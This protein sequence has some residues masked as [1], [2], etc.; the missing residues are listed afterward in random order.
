MTTLMQASQQWRSR[1]ADER[2][3]SLVE[4]QQVMHARR[5]LSTQDVVTTRKLTLYPAPDDEQDRR[6]RG[7]M[8]GVEGGPLAG[9]TLSPTHMAFGQLCSLAATPS[10]ASYFRESGL[11][12]AYIADCLNFNLRVTRDIGD[13]GVLGHVDQFGELRAATGPNYGRV[14]DADVVDALVDRFGDG[15]TE[16][17]RVPGEFGRRVT[18]T[19]ANTT[20]FASDRDMF[21]FLAD[22]ERRIDVAGRSLARG[23]FVWNSEVGDKTLGLGFFLFD[24]VCC[25]RIVWGADQYTEVRVRHTKGAPDRWLEEVAPVLSEYAEGSG[26][27][28]VE[29]IEAA[30]ERKIA[31]DLDKLLATRF[32]K[33]MVEPIKAIHLAEEGR[34]IETAWDVTVAATA[35]A[36][37]IPNTDKRLDIEREAG[38]LLNA[39]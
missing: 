19:Q 27:P 33:M 14:W 29:A 26:R 1:P 35:H 32:G 30:R 17:W 37:S 10:P 7:L 22:E 24:Y 8:I 18:V 13:I 21:V 16:H 38:A 28:V 20:L 6:R 2:F 23:F 11:P 9:Q 3:T 12:A 15:V 31:D 25:N 34:P 4:M 5:Q 39:A 36:R